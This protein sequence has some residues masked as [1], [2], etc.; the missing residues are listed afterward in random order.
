[1]NFVFVVGD[2]FDYG[3]VDKVL[4]GCC[5]DEYGF[6]FVDLVVEVC[7]LEFVFVVVDCL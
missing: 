7:N 4:V 5:Y 3:V 2:F 6:Y 1:M